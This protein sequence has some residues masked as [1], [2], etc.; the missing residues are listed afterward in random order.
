VE[1]FKKSYPI[2]SD[3]ADHKF[4]VIHLESFFSNQCRKFIS[5]TETALLEKMYNASLNQ[6]PWPILQI[7]DSYLKRKR[8]LIWR[9]CHQRMPVFIIFSLA[10]LPKDWDD[11]KKRVSSITSYMAYGCC[12][13]PH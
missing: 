9:G 5:G 7:S 13:Q 10:T 4:F 3:V 12:R 2:L 8:T 6:I 11:E 1:L